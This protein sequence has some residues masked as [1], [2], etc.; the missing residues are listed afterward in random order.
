MGQI[1]VEKNVGGIDGL[2]VITPTVHGDGRGYFMET[3]NQKDMEEAGFHI[4]FVQDN[5]SMSTKG[6]LR[7]L[8]FQKHFPQCKLVRAVRGSVF[9]VAVDLRRDSKTYGKW[10][11][12]ELTEENKDRARHLLKE[13]GLY[14]YRAAH[15]S[16]LSGGQKQRLAIACA[17]FSGRRILIL[18]EPTSGLDGQN[19]RL[20]AERLKSEARN[21]RTILVITHDRELIESC[22]DTVCGIFKAEPDGRLKPVKLRY[23]R[24]ASNRPV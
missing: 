17:I 20:I 19:M 6:V 18:D 16:A 7:G 9:D 3:Y 12:V 13:F 8:H 5:Q 15:P 1:Q 2:C 4:N 21:G 24:H 10:Y 11:G 14:E 22:C 23:R